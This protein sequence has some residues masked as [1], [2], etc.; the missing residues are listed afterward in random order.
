MAL[1]MYVALAE[2]RGTWQYVPAVDQLLQWPS[3]C[4]CMR[5]TAAQ[6]WRASLH[7][8]GMPFRHSRNS[9][10]LIHD[11][12]WVVRVVAGVLAAALRRSPL[13]VLPVEITVQ[14]THV[15]STVPDIFAR[16]LVDGY[17]ICI[18]LVL[19]LVLLNTAHTVASGPFALIVRWG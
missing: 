17:I 12:P 5:G 9:L 13:V 2:G 16:P 14:G 3:Q 11:G 1:V 19:S 10:S 4:T 6:W 7:G 18:P 15:H 8:P